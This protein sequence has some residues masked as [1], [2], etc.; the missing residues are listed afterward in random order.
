MWLWNRNNSSK[1]YHYVWYL[2]SKEADGVRGDTVVLPA[3][4]Q[5][6]REAVKKAPNKATVQVSNKGLKLIQSVL[7]VSKGGK[8]KM[9]LVKI[10]VA[11]NCITY[12]MTMKAPFNDVVGVVMLVLNPEMRNPM[13]VHCYRCDCPESASLLQAN[14]QLLIGRPENQRSIAAI[15]H[16]LFVNGVITECPRAPPIMDSISSHT[17]RKLH[18]AYEQN[19]QQRLED[20]QRMRSTQ[21]EADSASLSACAGFGGGIS[22]GLNVPSYLRTKR[23]SVN[24]LPSME[25]APPTRFRMFGD[26][27]VRGGEKSRSVDG[28]NNMNAVSRDLHPD[29]IRFPRAKPCD[30]FGHVY[31]QSLTV[32]GFWKNQSQRRPR[33]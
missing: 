1:S 28:L 29:S 13:H 22:G 12:S 2:G 20:H 9:Q 3:M 17:S 11:A 30:P 7:T 25:A 23:Y 10:G 24:D 31:K 32:E 16:R 26:T 8:V 5:L 27:F 15:E 21:S 18:R 14:L 4:R 19:L 6:L 33:V